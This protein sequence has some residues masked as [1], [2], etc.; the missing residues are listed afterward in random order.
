MHA[1]NPSV[2]GIGTIGKNCIRRCETNGLPTDFRSDAATLVKTFPNATFV[3]KIMKQKH[4]NAM[5]AMK[6]KHACILLPN[7]AIVT[8][9]M[10]QTVTFVR[11]SKH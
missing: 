3:Q 2:Y 4:T 10:R 1:H 8:A 11:Q 5:Y 6:Q 9:I 7:A